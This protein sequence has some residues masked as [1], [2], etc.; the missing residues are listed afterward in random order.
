MFFLG[1]MNSGQ[2]HPGKRNEHQYRMDA[3]NSLPHPDWTGSSSSSG[4]KE[5]EHRFFVLGY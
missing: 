4:C 3:Q 5:D 1:L 2:D